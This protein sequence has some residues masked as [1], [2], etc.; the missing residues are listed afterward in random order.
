MENQQAGPSFNAEFFAMPGGL[1]TVVVR[2]P[3]PSTDDVVEVLG[4][5]ARVGPKRVDGLLRQAEARCE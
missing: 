2:L 3:W 4:C 1:I 5:S